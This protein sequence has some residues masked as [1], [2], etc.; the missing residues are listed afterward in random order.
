MAKQPI[1]KA[2]IFGSCARGEERPTSD[3]DI[4]V[5]Y[6]DAVPISL[7]TIS[8]I[9]LMLKRLLNREV[10]LAEQD[11]VLPFAIEGVNRD[12]ILIY[13]RNSQG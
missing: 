11:G 8:K 4:L 9:G 6:D 2:W 12:K 3:V 5:Q 1:R 7:F 13:E 10:D